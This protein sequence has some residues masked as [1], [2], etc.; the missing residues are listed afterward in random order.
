MEKIPNPQQVLDWAGQALQ[1]LIFIGPLLMMVMGALY[2]F[3]AP[4]EANHHF[5]YR[6]YYGMG[7][8]EAWRFTQ[9]MAGITWL[10]VGGVLLLG[11][12]LVRLRFEGLDPMELFLRGV[13]CVLVQMA[14]ILLASLLIRLTVFFRFDRHGIRRKEKRRQR[15]NRICR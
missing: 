6:C 13:L 11:M 2:Y 8:V 9:R 3:A 5:G 1:V 14:A 4:K 10:S 15:K 12:L 7:S